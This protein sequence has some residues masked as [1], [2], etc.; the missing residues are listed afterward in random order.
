M[1][2]FDK[3]GMEYFRIAEIPIKVIWEDE[4]E[5]NYIYNLLMVSFH[6]AF[7]GA[8]ELSEWEV[9][10]TTSFDLVVTVRKAVP[11]MIPSQCKVIGNHNI[12][13]KIICFA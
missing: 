7:L 4:E 6:P 13:K 12:I 3:R 2:V 1:G 8:Y 10:E 11:G 9:N 5:K